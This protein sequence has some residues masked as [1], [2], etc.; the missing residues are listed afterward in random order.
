[1]FERNYGGHVAIVG[2][3]LSGSKEAVELT[4]GYGS[5]SY[6]DVLNKKKLRTRE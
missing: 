2:F 6:H 3:N 5:V 4:A 1:M